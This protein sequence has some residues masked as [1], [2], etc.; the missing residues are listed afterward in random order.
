MKNNKL[1]LKIVRINEGYADLQG[2]NAEQSW[3][4]N[5]WDIRKALGN[6]ENLNASS[7]V[8]MLTCIE[9]GHI[10]T[11]ASFI[12]GRINDCISGWIYIP[13]TIKIPGKE[14]VDVI[15]TIKKKIL[16]N[17]SN[18]E[19]ITKLFSKE[20]SLEPVKKIT[21][22]SSGDKFAYRYY[23]QGEKYTLSE[24]LDDLFQSY[25]N[26]YKGIFLIDHSTQQKCL[27]GDNLSNQKV[28]S[29]V[30]VKAP[31]KV[32]SFVPYIGGQP[33]EEDIYAIE[34]DTINVEWKRPNYRTIIKPIIVRREGSNILYPQVNE[35]EVEI[36][37]TA[38]RVYDDKGRLINNEDYSIQIN[39]KKL[40]KGGAKVYVNAAALSKVSVKV[41]PND[42][43]KYNE[44][45]DTFDFSREVRCN[46][47]LEG[48]S[49]S[50][51]FRFPK[52]T[53]Y[54]GTNNYISGIFTFEERLKK[55]PFKGLEVEGNKIYTKRDG[56][57]NVKVILFTKERIIKLVISSIV[58]LVLGI[59]IGYGINYLLN[60]ETTPTIESTIPS[61][62][63]KVQELEN[64]IN[65][66]KAEIQGYKNK[67]TTKE[68]DY[69]KLQKEQRAN[70]K[71]IDKYK[72]EN[73]ILKDELKK[74]E[75]DYL[76]LFQ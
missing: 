48:L 56:V 57:N 14:L 73:S 2:L 18:D 20:Y 44:S 47:Q 17:G 72:K 52:N 40:V 65:E 15:E 61:S 46:V 24:L 19:E 34:G 50:Y 25:Y 69:K 67:L 63:D 53:K 11:V 60:K 35:H 36:P 21:I 62:D 45:V 10:I 70:K 71:E 32:E 9:T 59:T 31:D 51:E 8:L 54:R 3:T 76:E 7:A 42:L 33:F 6:I 55:S 28:N 64:K 12:D 49:L 39:G 29:M 5:I 58:I 16:T 68:N 30:L 74:Y 75:N 26:N 13:S 1:G 37:F 38:I 66:Y 41:I 23:G 4:Q 22:K 43:D 27:S